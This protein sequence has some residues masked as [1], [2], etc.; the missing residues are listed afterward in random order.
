MMHVRNDEWMDECTGRWMYGCMCVC[1]LGWN[2]DGC[3][4]VCMYVWMYVYL[5]VCMDRMWM[6]YGSMYVCMYVC[7]FVCMYG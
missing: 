1:M 3:M 7:V 4:A 5:C 2:V 6:V